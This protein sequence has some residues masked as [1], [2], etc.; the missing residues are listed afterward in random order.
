MLKFLF[1]LILLSLCL[2]L[3]FASICNTDDE[4]NNGYCRSS[5]CVCNNGF[6]SFINQTCSYK[7]K[8]KL[9]AFLLSLFVGPLGVDWFYLANGEAKYIVAGVFKLLTGTFLMV[10]SCF[11][12]CTFICSAYAA[13]S[14]GNSKK[15]VFEAFGIVFG[16]IITVL[17]VLCSVANSIWVLVDIIRILLDKFPDG[18]GVP[19]KPW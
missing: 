15:G 18:S 10:G 13:A 7:Q 16:I 19:L 6:V 9:T 3:T 11:Y 5:K 12:C 8:D 14:D 1:G 17:M 4:C 2:N